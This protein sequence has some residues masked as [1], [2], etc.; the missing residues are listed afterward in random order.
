MQPG[1]DEAK[2]L[3]VNADDL[4]L[5]ASVNRAIFRA[6]REGIVTSSTILVGGTAFN[7]A[8]SGIKE[9]PEL[10]VG[11]HLCLVDQFPVSDP[12][13]I[14][15]LVNAEGRFFSTYGLFLRH[16][17]LGKIDL[18]DVRRELEA[19]ISMAIEGG[20]TPTHLD[21]HQ[22]LHLLPR[23][24]R[25]VF[26][27]SRKYG[28]K[29]IRIPAESAMSGLKA[30]SWKRRFQGKL[31]SLL[32]EA[33]RREFGRLGM[34]MPDHFVGFARGGRMD[35]PAWRNLIPRLRGGVTEVMVHPGDDNKAL[36]AYSGWDYHWSEELKALTDPEIRSSLE[37]HG[38]QLIHYGDIS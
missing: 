18:V 4:G 7:E 14:P 19:Q 17:L 25:L 30:D 33:R 2:R 26:D 31:V 36:T 1:M 6:H 34:L 12:V 3:I 11:V 16:Y 35:A 28:I 10:G 38:I 13:H 21:S 8:L 5:H 24:S 27:L 37:A 22:H 9:N 15:T 20:I 23:I 29:R 32:A